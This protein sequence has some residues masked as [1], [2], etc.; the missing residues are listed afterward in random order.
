MFEIADKKESK[1]IN[2]TFKASGVGKL[3]ALTWF[4]EPLHKY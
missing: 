1:F 3:L 4:E 2:L